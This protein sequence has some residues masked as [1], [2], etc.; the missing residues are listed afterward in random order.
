MTE[1][2]II[3]TT[4]LL[5]LGMILAGA[6]YAFDARMRSYANVSESNARASE[7]L[8]VAAGA[9]AAQTAALSA[10]SERVALFE[11][12]LKET[13]K[14]IVLVTDYSHDKHQQLKAATIRGAR[15]AEK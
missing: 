14:Q 2:I 9:F 3:C 10:L 1:T 11:A 8:E 13:V 12:A 6:K 5:A 15:H 4:A 7:K